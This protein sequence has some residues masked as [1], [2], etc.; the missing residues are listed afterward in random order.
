MRV[1]LSIGFAKYDDDGIESLSFSE[2]DAQKFFELMCDPALGN[3][4]RKRSRCLLSPTREL[5]LGAFAE[6]IRGLQGDDEFI[7][8]IAGHAA[9][10]RS[11]SLA[12]DCKDTLRHARS[13]TTL[14]E[15]DINALLR[16]RPGVR[17][18]IILDTCYAGSFAAL[19]QDE[20]TR[21]ALEQISFNASQEGLISLVACGPKEMAIES[22]GAGMFSGL[23]CEVLRSG[24]CVSPD[25][26][27]IR[28]GDAA[29]WIR[30]RLEALGKSGLFLPGTKSQGDVG[31]L[32]LTRNP[33]FG[34]VAAMESRTSVSDL[35]GEIESVI[36]RLT[37]R[38]EQ[39]RDVLQTYVGSLQSGVA[40]QPEVEVYR[41]RDDNTSGAVLKLFAKILGAGFFFLLTI[42]ADGAGRI[43]LLLVAAGFVLSGI[44]DV[45]TA[46]GMMRN[47]AKYFI[48][49]SP[50]GLV[51]ALRRSE[52]ISPIVIPWQELVSIERKT[53][54]DG[55]TTDAFV[56]I[57]D[58]KTIVLDSKDVSP[59]VTM[60][61]FAQLV[62]KH[63]ALK[64][65]VGTGGPDFGRLPVAAT[66]ESEERGVRTLDR[67]VAGVLVVGCQTYDRGFR[68]LPSVA[69]DVQRLSE[70]F[71]SDGLPKAVVKADQTL[72]EF[73]REV[74]A[75]CQRF[76]GKA[77]VIYFS[78]HGFVEGG[79]L[80]LA[81]RDTDP[82]RGIESGFACSKLQDVALEA[83]LAHMVVV[84]DCCFSGAA[85]AALGLDVLSSGSLRRFFQAEPDAV[86]I[87][88]AASK[89]QEALGIAGVGGFFTKAFAAMIRTLME[90]GDAVSIK[91]VSNG[92]SAQLTE[93]Q[94]DQNHCVYAGGEF[95]SLLLAEARR[96][97]Q[98]CSLSD[99]LEQQSTTAQKAALAQY[100]SSLPKSGGH[101]KEETPLGLL[102][103][104]SCAAHRP[105]NWRDGLRGGCGYLIVFFGGVAV[106]WSIVS[107]AANNSG[108]G[109][110]IFIATV[111]ILAFVFFVFGR[112]PVRPSRWLIVGP[113]GIRMVESVVLKKRVSKYDRFEFTLS[114]GSGFSVPADYINS[115][116]LER[117]VT[118]TNDDRRL[119]MK[120]H[121]SDRSGVKVLIASSDEPWPD[122]D[123]IAS[124]A[125]TSLALSRQKTLAVLQATTG[126]LQADH[127]SRSAKP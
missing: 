122:V 67:K 32:Y 61:M 85:G 43:L 41:V 17:G 50:D 62:E 69:D 126:M 7:L 119:V 111:V 102:H 53:L 48:L 22:R 14:T 6:L 116:V 113:A 92:V 18:T 13:T 23:L 26:E 20:R 107:S 76:R 100:A 93:A 124:V 68:P 45:A 98:A 55:V 74:T 108:L 70:L 72:R 19:A 95:E 103:Y 57:A 35:L 94:L 96:P 117:N 30:A 127:Q 86:T 105:A 46:V 66:A 104:F 65:A 12:F 37:R 60:D 75:L 71:S 33:R 15:R 118:T 91:A 83:G 84:L 8:F 123:R 25:Q 47:K 64:N 24:A 97:P 90:A 79:E 59:F 16:A 5:A 29:L 11:G 63:R 88:A 58:S 125:K 4:E 87:L 77:V 121:L 89:S 40:L 56:L 106:V 78:G 81:M 52:H 21:G 109:F 42:E 44:F 9:P 39:S 54:V 36:S 28:A 31:N 114:P 51:F 112:E 38:G 73:D 80:I 27:Y 49:F 1:V 115:Y 34:E 99:V 3:A 110:P 82:T 10:L 101:Y 2:G 120:L